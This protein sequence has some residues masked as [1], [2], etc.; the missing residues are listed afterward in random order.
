[1]V[2]RSWVRDTQSLRQPWGFD[3]LGFEDCALQLRTGQQPAA[4]CNL[5]GRRSSFPLL[6]LCIEWMANRKVLL[7]TCFAPAA[8]ATPADLNLKRKL[9]LERKGSVS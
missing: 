5:Y 6:V 3:H 2:C 7:D 1:M 4:I 9:F 8:W